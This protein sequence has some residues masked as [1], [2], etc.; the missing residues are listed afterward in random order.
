MAGLGAVTALG[1]LLAAQGCAHTAT[2]AAATIEPSDRITVAAAR[3]VFESYVTTSDVAEASSDELL[4][5]SL[6]TDGQLPLVAAAYRSAVYYGV[7][8]PRYQYGQPSIYVPR[9]TTFPLW[10]AVVAPRHPLRGGPPSTAVMVFSRLSAS[11]SWQLSISTV[12]GAGV[13]PPSVALDSGGYATALSADDQSLLAT[14]QTVGAL[15]ASVADDGRPS[16]ASKV[17]AAGPQTT[18]MHER[19]LTTGRQSTALGY[20][21]QAEVQGTGFPQFVLRT[22][23][24]GALM[25]YSMALNTVIS[26]QA[27]P[28]PKGVTVSP[29]QLP[30]GYAAL[31]PPDTP[32]IRHMFTAT[33]TQ[34]YSVLVP[35]IRAGDR[36]ITVIGF[37]GG[38]T[39]ATGH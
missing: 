35:P 15:Q 16:P 18:G 25:L 34:Q 30:D 28:L 6:V 13:P 39:L 36:K 26:R 24:G 10:F 20:F 37:S 19:I 9:P 17:V 12:L 4:A 2:P 8:Q 23:D 3:Q 1:L 29:I 21:Y 38:P 27:P 22:T 11:A 14:P 5:L 32:K 31:L 7:P 33:E